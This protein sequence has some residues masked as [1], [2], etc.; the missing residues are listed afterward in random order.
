VKK[1]A[2]ILLIQFFLILGLYAQSEKDSVYVLTDVKLPMS[3]SQEKEHSPRVAM[4]LSA[5]LP[6]AGQVYNKKIWK[7]PV[8]Y[9][10]FAALGYGASY[11]AE[12]YHNFRSVYEIALIDTEHS[13][14]TVASQD[15]YTV[16]DLKARRD[17]YRK[18]RDLCYIG[19]GLWYILNIIDA[20]VD[21]HFFDFD[22]SD[23]LTLKIEQPINPETPLCLGISLHF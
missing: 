21:A 1:L 4:L 8:I 18:Y 5:A 15:G 13:T 3:N 7:A 22:I 11:Y 16:A 19:G 12:L 6:G 10:G 2:G 20:N 23:D 17:F 9:V 14:F